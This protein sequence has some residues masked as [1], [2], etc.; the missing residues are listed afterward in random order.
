MYK[1]VSLAFEILE[2]PES[3]GRVTV[4]I[5]DGSRVDDAIRELIQRHRRD[6]ADTTTVG[7]AA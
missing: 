7:G 4:R 3:P 1:L 5:L 2:S 6:D